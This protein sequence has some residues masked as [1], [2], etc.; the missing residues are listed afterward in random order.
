MRKIFNTLILFILLLGVF[1]VYWANDE[2]MCLNPNISTSSWSNWSIISFPQET[3][4]ISWN[5]Y[6]SG[7]YVNK[8]NDSTII[9]NYLKWYYYD[10]IYWFFKLDWDDTWN[11]NVKIIASTTKCQ[12]WYWYKFSWF[13]AWIDTWN[14]RDIWFI[15]FDYSNDIYV[16]YCENDKKLH[17]YAYSDDLWFQNFEWISLEVLNNQGVLILEKT[18]DTFFTNNFTDI[19]STSINNSD[20]LQ[21]DI[22]DKENWKESIFYIIK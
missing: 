4:S 5:L 18:D 22:Y 14:W 20:S 16:Y 2:Q 9:W 8:D 17:W 7:Y 21:W 11:D 12:D 15:D 3:V 19:L 6:Y 13:A 10:D 1:V